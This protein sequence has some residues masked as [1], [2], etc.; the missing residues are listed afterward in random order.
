[1]YSLNSYQ[2]VIKRK[3]S[4][5][6]FIIGICHSERIKVNYIDVLICF[7]LIILSMDIQNC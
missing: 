6:L 7:C 4:S 3:I 1:M 2:K 5:Y